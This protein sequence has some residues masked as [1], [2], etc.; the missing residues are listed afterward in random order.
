MVHVQ[1]CCF[2]NKTYCFLDVLVTVHEVSGK[3][4]AFT[5]PSCTLF[6][7]YELPFFELS[8]DR[9]YFLGSFSLEMFLN[10][11]NLQ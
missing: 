10:F 3:I 2:A 4:V 7:L 11:N 6:F 5:F 9:S 1:S 8:P